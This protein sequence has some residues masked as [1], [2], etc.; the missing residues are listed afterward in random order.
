VALPVVRSDVVLPGTAP[1]VPPVRV[2]IAER[3]VW[4]GSTMM[5]GVRPMPAGSLPPAVAQPGREADEA[6]C[7]VPGIGVP[8]TSPAGPG[9]IGVP[10]SRLH[11]GGPA[12][13][14]RRTGPHD[15]GWQLLAAR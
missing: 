10:P 14:F 11:G 4:P 3:A 13:I 5:L 12:G 1:V 8:L 2:S 7:E 6:P 15:D 9:A